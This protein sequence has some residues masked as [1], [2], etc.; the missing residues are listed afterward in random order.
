MEAVSAIITPVVESLLVPIKRH[1]GFFFSSTKYDRDMHDK[2]RELK[3]AAIDMKRRKE[4]NDEKTLMVPHGVE[5]WLEQAENIDR[6]GD[7][8]SAGGN[9]CLHMKTRYKAGK[10][11]SNFIKRID[12][13]VEEKNKMVW[14]NEQ[15]PL[16]RIPSSA[17]P[18]VLQDVPKTIFDFRQ[19]IFERALQLLEPDNPT[20]KVA[21]FGIGGI[22]KTTMMEELKKVVENRKMFERVVR[23]VMGKSSDPIAFQEAIAQYTGGKLSESTKEARAVRLKE[24]LLRMS[25]DGR[26]KILIILDD[27]W[28]IVDLKDIGLASP[29]PKGFKLFLTSRDERLCGQMG[30]ETSSIL[31]MGGLEEAK[32]K[33][34]FW[35]TTGLSEGAVDH[36]LIKLGEDIVKRCSGLPMAIKTIALALRGEIKDA[37]KLTLSCLE[38]HDLQDLYGVAHDIFEISYNYLKNNDDKEIF[39]LSGLFP[40]DVD[41]PLEDLMRYAWGLKLFNKVYSLAEARR[42]TNTS[43]HNLIRANLL[44]ESDRIGC[45]KMHDLARSFVLS[46]ISKFKQASVVNH[47]DMSEWPTQD[48][49][50]SCRRFLLKC[51]GMPQFPKHF[52][53]PDLELLK[54]MMNDYGKEPLIFPDDFYTRMKKLQVIS[55]SGIEYP[56]LVSISLTSLRVLC[57][58]SCSLMGD[59]SYLGN[60]SN[61]EILSFAYCHIK[62]L[63]STVGNLKNLKLLDLTGCDELCIGNGVFQKLNNLK[64]LYMRNLYDDV[65]SFTE[66][67]CEGL[68]LISKKLTALEVE[69]FT[70]N[71]R[72]NNLSFKKL[73]RFRIS[74]GCQ[75]D[76]IDAYDNDVHSFENTLR[77]VGSCKDVRESEI[78]KLFKKT[79]KLHLQVEDMNHLEDVLMHPV[80]KRSF[81]YL[82]HLSFEK[83]ANLKHLFTVNVASTLTNLERF[84]VLSC[85]GLN[86]LIHGE[87]NGAEV[88]KFH[89]LKRLVLEELPMFV[90]LCDNIHIVVELPQL[91]ELRLAYL[92]KLTCIFA[93]SNNISAK[94]IS[95]LNKEVVCPKLEELEIRE[96]KNLKEIWAF[97]EEDDRTPVLK[98]IGVGECEEI[99]NLFPNNPMRLLSHLEKLTVINCGSIQALFKIDSEC[100]GK[101]NSSLRSIRAR[102]LRKLREVWRISGGGNSGLPIRGFQA[103]EMIKIKDC[104]NFRDIVTPTTIQ[105]D[106]S[107]AAVT[108]IMD[109][110]GDKWGRNNMSVEYIQDKKDLLQAV[111]KA[112]KHYHDRNI[113]KDGGCGQV[114]KGKLSWNGRL[115]YIAVSRF[116]AQDRE[117]YMNY[118]RKELEFLSAFKHENISSIFAYFD[119]DEDDDENTIIYKNAFHG[120]LQGHLRNPELTWSRRLQICLGVA[121]AL[122][123]IHNKGLIHCD[124]NSSKILL[125]EDWKP[126]LYGFELC[127]EFF[128]SWTHRLHVSRYVDTTSVMTPKYD[129]YL[130]GLLLFEVL[131]GKKPKLDEDGFVEKLD[132]IIDPSLKIQIESQSMKLF[133]KLANSCVEEKPV[134]R[135]TINQIVKELEENID[136][137]TNKD[138]GALWNRLPK[139]ILE[140]ALI[141]IQTATERFNEKY[142]VGCGA[143]GAVYKAELNVDIQS[144]SL[145]KGICKDEL[146]RKRKTVAIKRLLKKAEKEFSSEIELLSSCKHQN[147]VSLLGFCREKNERILVFEY[148]SKGT[149]SDYYRLG[150]EPSLTWSQRIQI[151]LHVAHGIH[152]LHTK[153]KIIHR[154]IKSDNILLDENLNAKV[155]DFGL[156]RFQCTVGGESSTIH[157]VNIAGTQVYLDPEYEV[158]G[159]LKKESD[160]YSFGVVLF[161]MLSGKMAYDGTYLRENDKGLGPV[162]RRRFDDETLKEL[163]DHKMLEDDEHTFTLNRGP[164]QESY[165]LFSEIGYKCLAKTQA[166]RPKMEDVIKILQDALEVQGRTMVISRF[167]LSSIKLATKNFDKKYYLELDTY[168]KVYKAQ[169]DH[170][171]ESNSL[172]AREEKSNGEPSKKRISAVIKR[173]SG[174]KDEHGENR[175]FSEIEMH[176]RYKHPNI[177][178]LL[179]FCYE[180]DNMLLVYEHASN[181]S[182]DNYLRDT[183]SMA[184]YT[185]I[186]RLHH[187]LGIAHGLNHLH[188]LMD[189]KQEEMIHV[190]IRSANILLGKTGEA[191]IAYS[192]FSKLLPTNQEASTKTTNTKVYCYPE[193]RETRELKKQSDIYSFG[194][195]LFEIFCGR[196]AYDPDYTV[197]NDYGLAPIARRCFSDGTIMKMI[198]PALKEGTLGDISTSNSKPISNSLRAYLRIAN[199]CL[200]ENQAE[201]PTVKTVIKELDMARLNIQSFSLDRLSEKKCYN[202][203][204]RDLSITWG[205]DPR[206]WRWISL[207]ESRFTE[208]A[209]LIEVCWLEV[210]GTIST[211]IL[212][213]DTRY[214]AYLVYKLTP[215]HPF[216]YY[217]VEVFIK[218]GGVESQTKTVYLDPKVRQRPILDHFSVRI[219]SNAGPPLNDPKP[220]QDEWLEIELGEFFN[221]EEV[222][223][224]KMTMKVVDEISWKHGIIIQG[225]DIRPKGS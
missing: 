188:N 12:R 87:K 189:R 45:V 109:S 101:V 202:L 184:K 29:F 172:L 98:E 94:G 190:D 19:S 177:V 155:A 61:L 108:T 64:E 99:Q 225:I 57:L 34:L 82:K 174:R 30:V 216:E 116:T 222:R 93:S 209:E 91:V 13:L 150:R 186:Q 132:D 129:V 16:S 68:E 46:N 24:R 90:G 187:C 171:F 75:L 28:N 84:T 77:L 67:N 85:G 135:P 133:I 127:T 159:K 154:D 201:R 198:D 139:E 106:I 148:A 131:L 208:V 27:L 165:N 220:R 157:T 23:V 80:S 140:I 104:Q 211:S 107:G 217:P 42:Q 152:Y 144:W 89:K 7:S 180:G 212:S 143:F 20:Q 18:Q 114:Y 110:T 31:K 115:M 160:I 166:E 40:D 213:T 200:A 51:N 10:Q 112:T 223:E 128:Q 185:W 3:S 214:A 163:I 179:G 1:L 21:L 86:S 39:I 96:M 83:C 138:K 207:P 221:Q 224:L 69:F 121:R 210:Q 103:M 153:P 47:S 196:L 161:E 63:P 66:D 78:S 33:Q 56:P 197:I 205:D 6:E 215:D 9:G 11:C 38:Q 52:D 199:Q 126:R 37:W 169:L 53:Y 136:C 26:K 50:E 156:S 193:Y 158:T 70:N 92:P 122:N 32:A 105:F 95:L 191:K 151:C 5:S 119:E 182:L 175:F 25:Q 120:N 192:R 41:I 118:F 141:E 146:P 15:I 59:L 149:L 203:A 178:P 65:I 14:T 176:T 183:D 147:V 145:T 60:L 181:G 134:D 8:I 97:E 113:I 173:I 137:S 125:D 4:E 219:Q 79:E 49:V 72:L 81:C 164:T 22:G 73:E 44:V 62:N 111:S 204:A 218:L 43:V 17:T 55:Y 71:I 117:S 124:I 54:L 35:E 142:Y 162:V 48:T 2:K 167:R 88:I 168:G 130:F 102:G 195:V 123:Y 58:R 100:V 36:Q 170:H 206:Y 74:I 76:G 194:V